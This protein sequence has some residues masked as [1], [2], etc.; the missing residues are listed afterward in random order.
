MEML[1]VAAILLALDDVVQVSEPSRLKEC[2]V[3]DGLHLL[4]C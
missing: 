4:E 2:L 1:A 3:E